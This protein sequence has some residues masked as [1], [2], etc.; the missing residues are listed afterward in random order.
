MVG[1]AAVLGAGL[2]LLGLAHHAPWFFTAIPALSAL[3]ALAAFARNGHSGLILEGDT[4]TLFKDPWRQVMRVGTI[5][6]VRVTRWSDGQADVWLDLEHGPPCRLPGYCFG[7]AA[8][9][10][11][12][13]RARGIPVR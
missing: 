1:V 9:L 8:E 3:M 12:A 4:L 11:E 13:F 7:S 10:T 6:S 2:A 5:R